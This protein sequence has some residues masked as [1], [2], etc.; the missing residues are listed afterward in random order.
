MTRE[1]DLLERLRN[2]N[3]LW[4]VPGALREEAAAEIERLQALLREV[5]DGGDI[6]DIDLEDR[7]KAALTSVPPP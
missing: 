7:I 2:K 5:L 4:T 3:W 1:P 6:F